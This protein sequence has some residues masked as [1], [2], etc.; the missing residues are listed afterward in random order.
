[1]LLDLTVTEL[2]ITALLFSGYTANRRIYR[3]QVE[4]RQL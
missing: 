4:Y 2:T 3:S 1:M